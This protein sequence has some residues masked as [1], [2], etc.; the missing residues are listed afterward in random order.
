MKVTSKRSPW[1]LRFCSFSFLLTLSVGVQAQSS[2][3]QQSGDQ[4]QAQLTRARV[5]SGKLFPLNTTSAIRTSNVITITAGAST[6][7][8]SQ[9]FSLQLPADA[10]MGSLTV[11]LNGHDVSGRFRGSTGILSAE[12]G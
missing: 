2:P 11:S 10:V 1:S 7:L 4:D 3:Q 9:T 12:D 8:G 5:F 6:V